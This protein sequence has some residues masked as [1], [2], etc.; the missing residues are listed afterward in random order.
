[1]EFRVCGLV[2]GFRLWSL[3]FRVSGLVLGIRIYGLGFGVWCLRF[4]VCGV[5]GFVV[6]GLEI[7]F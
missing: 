1:L 7:W 5:L 3:G 6:L 4:G 2:S